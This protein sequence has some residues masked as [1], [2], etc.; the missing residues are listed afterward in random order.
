MHVNTKPV[1]LAIGLSMGLLACSPEVEDTGPGQP[2][3]HR[4]EA[5]K[6]M[7]RTFEPMGVMLREGQYDAE[8]FHAMAQRLWEGRE[9]PWGYFGPETNYPPTK[10]R[11]AVWEQPEAFERERLQ[12]VEEVNALL[13]VSASHDKAQVAVAYKA[14]YDSC[15][16]CHQTFRR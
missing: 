13:T 6:E 7:L 16:S 11:P 1:L 2:V 8:R 15:K 12:F 10:S 9:S 14:V 3:K 4:Q 5:F